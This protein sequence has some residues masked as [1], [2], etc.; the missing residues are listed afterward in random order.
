MFQDRL[1]CPCQTAIHKDLGLD[2][3]SAWL[4][5]DLV[6][7]EAPDPDPRPG[8]LRDV[9]QQPVWTE[10]RTPT[11]SSIVPTVIPLP[12]TYIYQLHNGF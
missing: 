3:S 1:G 10:L 7:V 6:A 8:S 9:P 5:G 2:S 4:A 12:P 11:K